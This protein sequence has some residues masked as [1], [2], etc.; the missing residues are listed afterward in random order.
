MKTPQKSIKQ[1][2]TTLAISSAEILEKV[3]KHQSI[4]KGCFEFGLEP[5]QLHT[6]LAKEGTKI[7]R[8][9]D[10]V[11]LADHEK[12]DV[13]DRKYHLNGDS[14]EI[15]DV[16]NETRN[17]EITC[18]RLGISALGITNLLARNGFKIGRR[19]IAR[20]FTEEEIQTLE[21]QKEARKAALAKK[22]NIPNKQ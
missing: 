2:K 6:L 16:L 1:Q 20:P 13:K 22:Q 19:Y 14:Q 17:M 21:K 10:L 3:N 4:T 11:P 7:D 9:Y 15:I 5:Q 12:K 18:T 8:V